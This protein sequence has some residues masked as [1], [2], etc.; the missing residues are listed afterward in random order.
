MK[1]FRIFT[2]TLCVLLT[3]S[4]C[5]DLGD[6]K[7]RLDSLE[8][9]VSALEKIIPALNENVAALQTL[10]NGAT[11]VEFDFKD[12]VYTLKLSNDQTITLNQGSTGIGV[13]PVV[14]IDSDG[15]WTVDYKDG[16]GPKRILKDGEPVKAVGENGLTPI[17]G[18]DAQGYWTVKYI[19][20]G[21]P[22]RVLDESGQPVKATA[23]SGSGDSYFQSVSYENGEFVIVLNGSTEPLRI[24]VV[25][26]FY[27]R[28]IAPEGVEPNEEGCYE[29]VCS[30]MLT[31]TVES[32]GVAEHALLSKP[33]G[34]EVS[35]SETALEITA[36]A[37]FT[38]ASADSKT[39]VSI[40]AVS[41][42][43]LS[44]IAKILVVAVNPPKPVYATWFEEWENG[45]SIT[46][47]GVEYSK[48]NFEGAT[49]HITAESTEVG[50]KN[51][52][53]WFV[54]EDVTATLDSQKN[55]IVIGNSKGKRSKVTRTSHAYIAA[56]AAQDYWVM[57]NIDLDLKT[58][59]TYMFQV[60]GGSHAELICIDNCSLTV[61]FSDLSKSNNLIYSNANN[62]VGGISICNSEFIFQAG[63]T[64]NFINMGATQTIPAV[65]IDNNVFYT[66]DPE[67]GQTTTTILI[68]ASNTTVTDLKINRNTFYGA[69]PA[70][71]MTNCK[72]GTLE[73]KGNMFGLA[74]SVAS[75]LF[76]IGSKIATSMDIS[77]NAYYKNGTEGSSLYAVSNSNKAPAG[78]ADNPK[79]VGISAA[80]W[81][82][83]EGKFTIHA[84]YGATR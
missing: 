54:D 21:T 10:A 7:E 50:L 81:N 68:A 18:V 60:N 63:S 49:Y 6:I 27:F 84:E 83:A 30:S 38:K 8:S 3:I 77:G 48:A 58:S 56:T 40:L 17:F 55:I 82:P 65:N 14:G 43:G 76:V 13:A 34:F 70:G 35:L 53:I 41:D 64:A 74:S 22:E 24:P 1:R 36:P 9:R 45:N 39:D 32:K 46:I 37:S 47:G 2:A 19:A 33:E 57:H 80:G 71:N 20:D 26:N 23:A 28:L 62:T 44:C 52:G 79:S 42:D 73:V 25:S 78:T 69:Y 5:S 29:I 72:P 61:E 75:N 31:F 16:E 51:D 4:A 12:G 15:Y 59:T 11:I 67:N 66:A